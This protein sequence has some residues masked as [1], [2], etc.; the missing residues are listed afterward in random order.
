MK[1]KGLKFTELDKSP[2]GINS[3]TILEQLEILES[4]SSCAAK[5]VACIIF[6]NYMGMVSRGFNHSVS[7]KLPSCCD[8][9]EKK[10]KLWYSKTTNDLLE[11]QLSHNAW[12]KSFEVHAE[13]E[14]MLSFGFQTYRHSSKPVNLVCTYSPCTD[15]AKHIVHAGNIKRVYYINDYDDLTF[16]KS[17]FDKC[18]IELIK[19]GK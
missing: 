5:H 15:C 2:D 17:I 13:L 11:D 3:K 7:D 10:N 6:D 8:L 12:S 14:A 9:F 19:L 16:V 1:Y 4:Q 18:G